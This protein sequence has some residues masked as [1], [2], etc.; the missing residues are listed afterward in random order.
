MKFCAMCQKQYTCTQ[1]P[2]VQP[3]V[4]LLNV[5]LIELWWSDINHKF[6]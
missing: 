5:A 3:H 2:S 1:F 4:G 6:S